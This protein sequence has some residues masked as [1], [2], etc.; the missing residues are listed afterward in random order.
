MARN[1]RG[2][3]NKQQQK[4]TPQKKANFL[5]VLHHENENFKIIQKGKLKVRSEYFCNNHPWL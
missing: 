1:F 5:L 2:C 3:K 4:K